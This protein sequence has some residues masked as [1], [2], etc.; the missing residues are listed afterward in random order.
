MTTGAKQLDEEPLELPAT[1]SPAGGRFFYTRAG[2]VQSWSARFTVIQVDNAFTGSLTPF[3][4]SIFDLQDP[5]L[6]L[7]D[8]SDSVLNKHHHAGQLPC[9]TII[10]RIC[11]F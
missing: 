3:V 11:F 10:I 1:R 2:P 6:A 7:T 9:L 8:W 5:N 4:E